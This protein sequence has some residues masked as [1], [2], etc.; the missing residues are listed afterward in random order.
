MCWPLAC[1]LGLG[2]K[3]CFCIC[4]G[5]FKKKKEKEHVTPMLGPEN[6]IKGDGGRPSKQIGFFCKVFPSLRLLKKRRK[7]I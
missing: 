7:E 2:A 6:S 3:N 1:F 4:E 5:L